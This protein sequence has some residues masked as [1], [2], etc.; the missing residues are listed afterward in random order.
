MVGC[1]RIEQL[2]AR[3]T[4]P[5]LWYI[6]PIASVIRSAPTGWSNEATRA[7]ADRA[8]CDR[9]DGGA[10]GVTAAS[11]R[12]QAAPD[13]LLVQHA[14]A[15]GPGCQEDLGSL[16]GGLARVWLGRGP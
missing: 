3:E 1:A 7:S 5:G 13:R 9:M 8:R 12:W 11:H 15:L 16:F 10:T 6:E 14:A 4:Q 2:R